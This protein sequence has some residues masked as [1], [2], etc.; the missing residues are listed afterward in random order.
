MR[1]A[2]AKGRR[3]GIVR[4]VSTTTLV[5]DFVRRGDG[6]GGLRTMRLVLFDIDGTLI[7]TGGAGERAFDRV[8]ETVFHI[9]N[10]TAELNFVGR[11]DASIVR[12]FFGQHR[13]DPTPGNFARFY[14]SYVF[15]LDH[16]LA[17]FEGCVLPGVLD[18]LVGLQ[19]WSRPPLIGL[20]TGNI[21]LGAQIKLKHFGLWQYFEIGAFGDDHADRNALAAIAQ[22]RARRKLGGS[23][24]GEQVVVVG[25]TPLDIACGRAIQAKVLAVATGRFSLAELQSH[26]PD[27]A[28]SALD[29]VRVR[30]L[31]QSTGGA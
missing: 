2:R 31:C 5:H 25:D 23:V 30:D 20:L 6:C 24:P 10:G 21:R 16:L 18:L 7:Q 11:T 22:D 4:P 28:V 9:P 27:W 17:E 14:D 15:W 29:Q 26:G 1:L 8:C 19:G 13:I 3:R 12:D